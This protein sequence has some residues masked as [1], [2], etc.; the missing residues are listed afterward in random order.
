M[1]KADVYVPDGRGERRKKRFIFVIVMV[2]VTAYLSVLAA[3]WLILRNPVFRIQNVEVVGNIDVSGERIK[4]VVLSR[5]VRGSFWRALI[6]INN[7]LIWPERLSA[8][9][10]VFLPEVKSV[11]LEKDYASRSVLINVDERKPRGIWCLASPPVGDNCWWFDD[12]GVLFRRAIFAEGSLITVV[13][14]YSQE[15]FGLGYKILP[16]EFIDNAFS[17]FDVVR[18][19]GLRIKEVRLNDLELEEVEV[20][21]FD[22]PRVLFS[23]RFPSVNALE[24]IQKLFSA[25]GGSAPGGKDLDY[26]D[27]RVENR[28]YYK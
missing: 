3:G 27:F 28:V 19:S 18:S 4:G 13:V 23:L 12:A 9:D 17:V 16:E 21:T 7:V 25:K 5:I 1:P 2:I 20:L 10:L 22:G 26:L 15:N 11:E 24:V 14:D 6:G 8:E